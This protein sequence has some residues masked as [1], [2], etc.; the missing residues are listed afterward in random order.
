MRASLSTTL[1]ALLTVFPVASQA[2]L[3]EDFSAFDANELTHLA[4]TSE[5]K[6]GALHV[7]LE[8]KVPFPNVAIRRELDLG[9]YQ[10]VEAEL[11]NLGDAGITVAAR[12]DNGGATGQANHSGGSVTL[13]PG[14]TGVLTVWF[15]R[16]SPNGFRDTLKGMHAYPDGTKHGAT[17]DPSNVVAIQFFGNRPAEPMRFAVRRITAEGTFDPTQLEV[18]Q[19]FFPF[20]DALGQY[21]HGEWPGKTHGV[22]DLKAQREKEE[23]D[24]AAHPGAADRDGTG[25][26][27]EGPQLDATGRFRTV[28]QDG[29]WWLVTPQGRLFWSLGVCCVRIGGTTFVEERNT[30]FEALPAADDPLARFY[31][32]AKSQRG[33]YADREL[34]TFDFGS[35]NAWRKY[36][37]GW[38]AA[39]RELGHRRL[40]SWGF[41]TL[42]C[43]SDKKIISLRRT[44]YVDWIFYTPPRIRGWGVT[45]KLFPDVF[46]PRFEAEFRRRAERLCA[47]TKDDPLCIGYFSDNELSWD[48]ETTLA[49]AVLKAPA[50]QVAKLRMLEWLKERYTGVDALNAAWKTDFADWDALLPP[51]AIYATAGTRKDLEDFGTVIAR[52][53]FETCKRVLAEVAPGTLYLGCRFATHNARAVQAAA[54]FCDVVSFNIYRTSVADW[55]PPGGIDKPVLIGEFHFGAPDRGVFGRGLVGVANQAER[56]EAVRRYV[57]GAARNPALVGAHWFQ[58]TDEPTSGRPL[59]GENHQVG[60]VDICNTPHGGTLAAFREVGARLYRLRSQTDHTKR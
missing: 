6:D 41:N 51:Q 7:S 5:L 22:E 40:K 1:L 43:W 18:P 52:T 37:D 20:I 56:A 39:C 46:D 34:K 53:Y 59:D 47:D 32:M 29:R 2:L 31:G 45:R 14:E 4:G 28:K 54:E 38:E 19:P 48:D 36:G 10:R 30:W 9:A 23:A 11:T 57:E 13:G 12:V 50:D 8:A 26:W 58:Y 16:A 24:L 44:P 27:T 35:A 42:G 33:D 55:T 25:G 49:R 3:I 15:N 21:R 17:L 60:L